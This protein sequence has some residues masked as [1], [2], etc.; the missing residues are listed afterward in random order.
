MP[1]VWNPA[2]GR[3]RRSARLVGRTQ[4]ASEVV[5]LRREVT[6][7][8]TKVRAPAVAGLF[9]PD[10]PDD[11]QTV[12]A[13]SFDKARRDHPVKAPAPKAIIVP[14]AGYIYSGPVAA[15]AYRLLAATKDVITRVVL[16]GP[17]HRV[18]LD[19]LAVPSADALA[20]PL[21]LVPVDIESRDRVLALPGVVMEDAPH[22]AE[23]SLEVHLPFLQLVLNDISVLPLLVGHARAA[24]VATVLDAVWGGPET[25]FVIS[26]DLSHYH[27]YATARTLDQA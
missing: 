3:V 18:P 13:E 14:H 4:G 10:D 24:M 9:Y 22:A 26:T 20:T 6:Q 8:E 5:G 21:G 25:L 19:G 7:M 17:S 23:H 27:D 1:Y 16:L 15:S 2:P 12:L 11:L